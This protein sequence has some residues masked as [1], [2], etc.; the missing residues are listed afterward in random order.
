LPLDASPSEFGSRADA[1]LLI[2]DRAIHAPRFTFSEQWDLGQ[3]WCDW[4]GLP[5][6]FAMWTARP[7]VDTGRIAASLSRARDAGLGGLEEIAAAAGRR[8]GLSPQACHSYLRNN[9][10]FTL[11]TDE[12]KGLQ[13]F[14]GYASQ[15]GLVERTTASAIGLAER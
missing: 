12:Q 15:H 4:T 14:Y 10:H 9:L 8:V 7:G 2:G 13:L 11:G 6:V 5:F 3:E 1:I